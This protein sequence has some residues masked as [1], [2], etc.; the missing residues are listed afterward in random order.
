[1]RNA[2]ESVLHVNKMS[3]SL[4][5]LSSVGRE[6]S[7]TFFVKD[8]LRGDRYTL[9]NTNISIQSLK[10]TYAHQYVLKTKEIITH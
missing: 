2:R 5:C 3:C 10:Y 6:R 1:M 8:I 4:S 7:N 9:T